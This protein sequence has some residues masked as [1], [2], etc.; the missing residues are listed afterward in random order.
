M[1]AYILEFFA[2]SSILVLSVQF[3][4]YLQYEKERQ[5]SSKSITATANTCSAAF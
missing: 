5:E 3:S 2:A 4:C 1:L